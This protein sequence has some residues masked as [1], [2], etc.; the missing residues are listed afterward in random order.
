MAFATRH[1]DGL[2]GFRDEA[3]AR[4]AGPCTAFRLGIIIGERGLRVANPYSGRLAEHFRHGI[5]TGR[6]NRR[7]REAR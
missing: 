3:R 2:D 1:K 4:W 7:K 6:E 5:R